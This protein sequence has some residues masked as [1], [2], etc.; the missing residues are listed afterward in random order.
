M[1]DTHTHLYMPEFEGGGV[2][3]VE[4]A[5]SAGVRMMVFPDVSPE[6]TQRMLDLAARYPDSVRIAMGLHPTELGDDWRATL[7]EVF[8]IHSSSSIRPSAI[9]ETGIDLYWDN[10]RES[11]QRDAFAAHLEMARELR[12]PVIIHCR[13]ALDATIDVI[14]DHKERHGGELPVLIFHS[15]TG[16][17]DDVRAIRSVCDPW[18]GIGGVVT[19]RNARGLK[20]AVPEIGLDRILLETDSPYLAPV[21][22][23]GRR[24]ESAFIVGTLAEV[25]RLLALSEDE[26]E[27]ATDA[28]ALAV[29]NS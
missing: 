10:T 5:L 21:P 18:F 13:E 4:R 25:A 7:N 12:L 15:F 17:S 20:A 28:N 22:F 14:Y 24:N 1:I 26:V 19:F 6:T 8:R 16:D 27:R 3:A 2:P 11:E 9:G 23:R 29:F